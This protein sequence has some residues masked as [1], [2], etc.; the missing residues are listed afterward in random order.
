MDVSTIL[1]LDSLLQTSNE[2]PEL[3]LN[4]VFRDRPRAIKYW[5]ER[6]LIL[7]VALLEV[8]SLFLELF[9][10]IDATLLESKLA[11]TDETSRAMPIVIWSVDEWRL[12]TIHVIAIVARFANH[13]LAQILVSAT[14]IAL[15][16]GF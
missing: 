10:R 12:E 15:L 14:L 11:I 9:E 5:I 4:V 8:G 13:H 2:T 3:S 7:E 6:H 16:I 1:D